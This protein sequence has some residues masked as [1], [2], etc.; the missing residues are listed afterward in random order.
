[1]WKSSKYKSP[2]VK[3]VWIT[4]ACSTLKELWF[5][6][7]R[8][9]FENIKPNEQQF[10][11]RIKK[12][13]FE[14]GLRIKGN[15]WNQNYDHRIISFFNLGSRNFKFQC[16]KECYWFPPPIGYTMFCC[17]G[18]SFG[19]PG[20]AGFGF[21]IRDHVC[22]VIGV[23]SGG[24]GIATN[25]IAENYALLCAVELAGEWR[26]QNIILCSD[27]KT[28]IEDF[29][30][31][32]VPWFIRKR[33]QKATSKVSSIIFQ[34]NLREVKF[35]ADI[36]AKQGA[37]LAAGERQMILGRPNFLPEL[38]CQMLHITGFVREYISV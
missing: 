15:K 3:E 8:K 32:Q 18:S 13:V 37:R 38:K 1:M 23:L 36:A 21:V 11:C 14:G 5:Q 16:I 26:L 7:N 6:K 35:S 20:T 29:A 34:H 12:L 9:I 10:K 33:W 17:D 28:I 27:S 22:Q 31:D 4:A 19:N 2:L 24:L 30:R 25:Y